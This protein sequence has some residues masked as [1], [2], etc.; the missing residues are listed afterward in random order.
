MTKWI[1]QALIAFLVA[2]ALVFGAAWYGLAQTPDG[3]PVLLITEL[4]AAQDQGHEG[5]KRL[6]MQTAALPQ[7]LTIPPLDAAVPVKLETATFALG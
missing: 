4:K 6:S 7:G 2:A 3:H 5:K 1:G